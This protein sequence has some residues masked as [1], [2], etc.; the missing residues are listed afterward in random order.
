VELIGNSVPSRRD[1]D[2]KRG[3]MAWDA[4]LAPDEERVIEFGYRAAWPA[5]KNVTYGQ[6]S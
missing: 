1:V 4:T 2:D 3:V 5:A 6:G